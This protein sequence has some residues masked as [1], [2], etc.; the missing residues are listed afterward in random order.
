MASTA[1]AVWFAIKDSWPGRPGRAGEG[2]GGGGLGVEGII[3]LGTHWET[4]MY[5]VYSNFR[6]YLLYKRHVIIGAGGAETIRML[7]NDH[8]TS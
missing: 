4:L 8:G 2:R 5:V 3:F 7:L 6:K 1:E